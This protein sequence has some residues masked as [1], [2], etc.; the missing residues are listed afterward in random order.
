MGE[1]EFQQC[2]EF[3]RNED[4]DLDSSCD[5]SKTS[6]EPLLKKH[7]LVSS[8]ISVGDDETSESSRL[9]QK[10]NRNP[11]RG[12]QIH[13][14]KAK[15]RK[16]RNRSRKLQSSKVK[17]V[18]P[19]EVDLEK[20]ET[21]AYDPAPLDDLKNFMDSLLK[22]LKVTRENLLKCMMEEMQYLMADDTT[23]EPK[24]RKLRHRRGRSICIT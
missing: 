9:Q 5:D 11:G 8:L 20:G 19:E 15:K 10:D 24:W 1:L 13:I 6:T 22:D 17:R 14:R 18:S 23:P 7:K 2:R 16:T 3:R 21:S 12:G 4:N